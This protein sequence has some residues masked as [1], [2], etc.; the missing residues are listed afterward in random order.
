MGA[1]TCAPSTGRQLRGSSPQPT[2]H[3]AVGAAA[4]QPSS[5]SG[6]RVRQPA[7]D[8]SAERFKAG[9]FTRIRVLHITDRFDNMVGHLAGLKRLSSAHGTSVPRISQTGFRK[10]C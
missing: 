6:Y 10:R 8:H 7:A 4:P 2:D 3:G 9:I 5:A 1:A